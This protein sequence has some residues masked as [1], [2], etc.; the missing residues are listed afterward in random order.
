MVIFDWFKWILALSINWCEIWNTIETNCN[1]HSFIVKSNKKVSQEY[2]TQPELV[3]LIGNSLYAYKAIF[4][5]HVAV[6]V[7]LRRNV[8]LGLMNRKADIAQYRVEVFALLAAD[9]NMLIFNN[10]IMDWRIDGLHL[11]QK[12][13]ILSLG[14]LNRVVGWIDES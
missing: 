14:D 9:H 11:L 8:Y 6:Q 3:K 10:L 7:S 2:R 12:Y 4:L 1:L 13:V 5:W